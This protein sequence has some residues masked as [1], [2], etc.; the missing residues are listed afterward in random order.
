VLL[1]QAQDLLQ[2]LASLDWTIDWLRVGDRSS[3]FILN[4]EIAMAV[5]IDIQAQIEPGALGCLLNR[6]RRQPFIDWLPLYFAQ[7]FGERNASRF[8]CPTAGIIHELPQTP[9]STQ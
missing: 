6:D 2:D 5:G 3:L 9:V 7:N 4:A 1:Q 8:L